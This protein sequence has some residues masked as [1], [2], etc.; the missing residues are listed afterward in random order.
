MMILDEQTLRLIE[1]LS[2]AGAALGT[3]A[4]VLVSLW[5]A[6]REALKVKLDAGFYFILRRSDPPNHY[7]SLLVTNIGPRPVRVVAFGVTSGRAGLGPFGHR[8]HALIEL[9]SL[10]GHSFPFQLNDGEE[11]RFGIDL[12]QADNWIEYFYNEV[13]GR[14]SFRI[15]TLRFRVHVSNGQVFTVQPNQLFADEL[16]KLHAEARR[17]RRPWRRLLRRDS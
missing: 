4:A 3:F 5:L 6:R 12:D 1:V 13:I 14:S 11:A 16:W 8:H 17:Q 2:T 7:F 9:E 15:R 10:T